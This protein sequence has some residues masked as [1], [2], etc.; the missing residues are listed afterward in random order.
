[1]TSQRS[2]F[3]FRFPYTGLALLGEA[4]RL[5]RT[6]LRSRSSLVAENLFLRKQLAFY[7][8]RNTRSRRLT[9]SARICLVLLSRWFDWRS[10]LVVVQPE[11]LIG[12]HRRAFR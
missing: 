11:T 8:E 2:F 10:A 3:A 9:D 4:V 7:Q 1:M 6:A 12:W 5:G